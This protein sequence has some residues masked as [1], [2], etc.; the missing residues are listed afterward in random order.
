M[1]TML[2]IFLWTCTALFLGLVTILSMSAIKG[3]FNRDTLT[4]V[5]ALLNGIDIQGERLRQ[6]IEQGRAETVQSNVDISAPSNAEGLKALQTDLR[7]ASLDRYKKE[8]DDRAQRLK[9]ASDRHNLMVAEFKRAVDK[10][11]EEQEN[12]SMQQVKEIL[13]ALDPA[14]AKGQIVSML[15][16]GE[17]DDV[18]AILKVLETDKLKKILVEFTDL[19][20]Q[21]KIAEILEEIRSRGKLASASNSSP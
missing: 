8:L 7:S 9:E 21:Q 19:S 11:S 13:E 5:I 6:A 10:A 3:H 2:Q 4:R 16:E 17:K 18:L 20:D 15:E 14:V 12:A 1:K